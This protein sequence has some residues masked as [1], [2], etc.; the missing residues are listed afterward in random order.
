M[1]TEQPSSTPQQPSRRKEPSL[2]P[3]SYVLNQHGGRV[4][5]PGSAVQLKGQQIRPTVYV[6][7]RLLVRNSALADVREA[8][9]RAA[10]AGG[11]KTSYRPVDPELQAL[12]ERYELTEL[13]GRV[14][15][16]RVEFE[17]ASDQ[18][19]TP[20]DAWQVLQNFRSLVGP[21]SD[22][23]HQVSLEH[24]L[25]AN[26]GNEPRQWLCIRM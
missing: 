22:Q 23:S 17:P 19:A 12:A 5:E 3:P 4:L 18:P 15:V 16:T 11:L 6:G 13:A 9:D 10:A 1:T 24:L 25:A 20:P 8:L 21:G 2:N 7:S 14:L 26:T